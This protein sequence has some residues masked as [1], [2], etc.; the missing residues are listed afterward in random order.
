MELEISTGDDSVVTAVV[1][2]GSADVDGLSPR[3]DV[4]VG[5]ETVGKPGGSSD[6][7]AVML[8]IS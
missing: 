7:V 3:D 1:T 8:C 5:T 4:P 2:S 6:V